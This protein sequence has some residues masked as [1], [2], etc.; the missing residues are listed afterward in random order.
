MSLPQ[1]P[2]EIESRIRLIQDRLGTPQENPDD[3]EQIVHL[4]H[5][6][7]NLRQIEIYSQYISTQ[8]SRS[9]FEALQS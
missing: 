8:H 6:W 1:P 5:H 7:G 4:C 2:H 9:L 3:V